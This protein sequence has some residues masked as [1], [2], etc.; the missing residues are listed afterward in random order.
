M[1]RTS[2]G[3]FGGGQGPGTSAPW[4]TGKN[5]PGRTLDNRRG[6][7]RRAA[8]EECWSCPLGVAPAMVAVS[9]MGPDLLRGNTFRGRA[10]LFV[11]GG[12]ELARRQG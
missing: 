8:S 2:I 7:A 5:V 6:V 12:W 9:R 1:S 4:G 10:D 3:C 11:A